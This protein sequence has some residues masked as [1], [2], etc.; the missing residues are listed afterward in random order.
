MTKILAIETTEKQGSVAVSNDGVVL[1]CLSLDNRMRSAQS[2]IP[3]IKTLLADV[4]ISTQLIDVI[5]VAIGPGSFTGLRV[6]L[7]TA[8]MLAYTIGA[9]LLGINTLQSI[10]ANLTPENE[11]KIGQK[12]EQKVT[13]AI[14]AQRGDVSAQTFLLTQGSH[15]NDFIFPI[16]QDEPQLMSFENWLNLSLDDENLLFCGPVLKKNTLQKTKNIPLVDEKYWQPNAVGVTRIAWERFQAGESD[17]L[18][19][20]QP[21]YS[22]LSA[23][24][25]KKLSV[26]K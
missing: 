14:D 21:Y 10:A 13:V 7:A 16:P 4:S 17:D 5:A 24:E 9:K 1:L 25:E 6:G 26:K 19:S 15:F 23:A 8:R 18:W 3:A 22:R 11:G 20:L 12:I 2:L